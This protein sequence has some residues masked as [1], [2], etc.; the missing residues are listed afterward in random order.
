M[1]ATKAKTV[2]FYYEWRWSY[3]VRSAQQ[4]RRPGACSGSYSWAAGR[5]FHNFNTFYRNNPRYRVVAFTATQI[6]DY[7]RA[8]YPA[9]L[10]G[11]GYPEGIQILPESEM[12]DII[13]E[14]QV[15]EVVFAYSDVSHMNLSCTSRHK[16]WPAEPIFICLVRRAP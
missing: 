7:R 12:A 8:S 1:L 4:R 10:A 3:Y 6:P 2:V 14:Q 9:V 15:D 13:R 5:D 11:E 16:L